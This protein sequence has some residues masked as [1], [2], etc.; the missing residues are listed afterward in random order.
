MILEHKSGSNITQIARKFKCS[1]KTVRKW[2][3]RYS[4]KSKYEHQNKNWMGVAPGRGRKKTITKDVAILAAAM[5]LSG[6]YNGAQHVANELHKQGKVPGLKP[7]HRTTLVKHAKHAAKEEM[8]L[9]IVVSRAR[10][11]KQLTEKNIQQRYDFCN[12]N[13]RRNWSHVMFTDRKK[14]LLRYPGAKVGPCSYVV[15]GQRRSAPMVSKPMVVNVYAGITRFGVTKLHFVAGTSKMKT[16]HK[17]KKGQDARN[18]TSSE[19]KEVVAKT[20]LPEARRIFSSQGMSSFIL[21]QDNDPTH[22]TASQQAVAEWNAKHNSA[23]SIL[24]NWPPNSPDLSLIENVW[25][26]V[27]TRVNQ[28]GCKNFD[29]FKA[30]VQKEWAAIAKGG[31]LKGLWDSMKERLL[32]CIAFHGDKTKY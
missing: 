19:Y 14:F 7:P 30:Q 32:D 27:Q 17:N 20:F 15:K 1:H 16:T 11:A 10:P 31:T 22:K 3:R 2:V 21:Q 4:D 13:L 25:G 12:A 23:I 24:P 8:D 6:E 26:I 18:V 5:L 9:E 29:E 28:A